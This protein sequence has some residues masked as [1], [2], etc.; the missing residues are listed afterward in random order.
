MASVEITALDASAPIVI[1][2]Q[3]LNRQDGEDEYHVR[4][5][6]LGE[7]MDPES[8]AGSAAGCSSRRSSASRRRR[9]RSRL[10]VRRERDDRLGW[11][12]PPGRV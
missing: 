11:L 1:S 2:S 10:P 5:A 6:A 3:L 7:G 4:S 9:R 12:S 8:P